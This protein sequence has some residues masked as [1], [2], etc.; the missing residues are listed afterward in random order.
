M[1]TASRIEINR[2]NAQHSTGPKSAEGKQKSSMNALQHGLTGQI[3]VMPNEDQDAYQ[4]HLQSFTDH[5]KPVGPIEA[6]LVQALADCS[7]RQNR[8]AVFENNVQ[9]HAVPGGDDPIPGGISVGTAIESMSKTLAN[10]SLHTQRLSRQFEKTEKHLRELQEIRKDQEESD[11]D[12]YLDITEVYEHKG[13]P[14]DPSQ[15][16]F[17]FSEDQINQA[18]LRRNRGREHDRALEYW[19]TA[20]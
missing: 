5:L 8:I 19:E 10:L 11:L 17:V 13:E 2:A 7:W 15:D 14:Y 6:N 4:Q 18:I 16:G 20:A 9:A 3:V 12:K 1:S